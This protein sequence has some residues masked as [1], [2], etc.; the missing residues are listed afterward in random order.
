MHLD[1]HGLTFL[2]T[3]Q[4]RRV[5]APIR[6]Q[7]V[8]PPGLRVAAARNKSTRS[9]AQALVYLSLNGLACPKNTPLPGSSMFPMGAI[10]ARAGGQIVPESVI[11]AAAATDPGDA[12]LGSRIL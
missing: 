4:L 8:T 6:C 7:P 3:K 5:E 10:A 9:A 12:E 11:S 2:G 1:A